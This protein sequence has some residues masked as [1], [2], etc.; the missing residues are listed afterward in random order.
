M[1][2]PASVRPDVAADLKPSVQRLAPR[3]GLIAAALLALLTACGGSGGDDPPT[4]EPATATPTPVGEALGQAEIVTVGAAGGHFESADGSLSIDIPAG[5]L[6][7]DTVIRMQRITSHAHGAKG[8]GWRLGPE[9][10]EFAQPVK[11]M[12]YYTSDDVLGTA[13]GLLRIA[14][15]NEQGFWELHENAQLDED[16]AMLTVE[17]RHF[18]D[19]SLLAGV[20][21][22]PAAATIKPGESQALQ[23]ML[24]E[25]VSRDQLAP[26][27][28]ECRPSQVVSQLTR[29]WSVNGRP[30]GDATNGTVTV[31][32]DRRALYTAPAVA[33]TPPAV[34]VS[35]EYRGLQG[36]SVVLVADILVQS[37]I[38]TP[39]AMGLPCSFDLTEFNRK[40]LP[41]DEL[42]RN[43]WENPESVISGRLTLMDFDG[44]GAGN[45]TLRIH[46]VED[47]MAGPLE[48]FEQLG[49]EFTSGA[50]GQLQFTV[51]GGEPFS[52]RI[53][54]GKVTITGYTFTTKNASV[55]AELKFV[56]Q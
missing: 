11:L 27:V 7:E 22:H 33:P 54:Q 45:W 35:T 32:E 13:P 50:N 37:G 49:G 17:T 30:G 26:L 41:Y 25:R 2:P 3:P 46:W 23:V 20:Q 21:L 1:T 8:N 42:P 43:D 18:S 6:A 53:E 52:G 56:Q 55:V 40:G 39:P 44:D 19:W 15:Q 36:E 31:Q 14:S 10:V 24:C 4:Q 28:A 12:F 51:A 34:A 29:N 38:C 16:E 48:Q 5:A 47:R 9:G